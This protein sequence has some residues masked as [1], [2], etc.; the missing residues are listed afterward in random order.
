MVL[1]NFLVLVYKTL[2]A[3]MTLKY[4]TI[5]LERKKLIIKQRYLMTN[6]YHSA[7]VLLIKIKLDIY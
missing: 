5:T 4:L 2:F 3:I 7:P 6:S 1:L